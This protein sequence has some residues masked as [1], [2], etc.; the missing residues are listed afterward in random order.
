MQVHNPTHLIWLLIHFLQIHLFFYSPNNLLSEYYYAVTSAGGNNGWLGGPACTTC[1]QQSGF[2][3]VNGSQVL[4]AF[5]NP[6]DGT[7]RV[8]FISAGSP[9]TLSEAIKTTPNGVWSV[10]TMP[11][12]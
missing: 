6:A 9:G 10:S 8:G 11:G 2:F 5:E 7:I 3:G 12:T 4:Y 1:I